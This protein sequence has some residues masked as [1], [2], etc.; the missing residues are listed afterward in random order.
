MKDS[1]KAT[2]CLSDD[3]RNVRTKVQE[4]LTNECTDLRASCFTGTKQ[5]TRSAR[6]IHNAVLQGFAHS[7]LQKRTWRT[8]FEDHHE[9]TPYHNRQNGHRRP[10]Q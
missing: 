2:V 6:W 9:I 4:K 8:T 3:G 10:N 7:A 5:L 1:T